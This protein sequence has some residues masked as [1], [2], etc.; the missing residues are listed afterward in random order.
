M[1]NTLSFFII[2]FFSI[3]FF[4]PMFRGP[5]EPVVQVGRPQRSHST[6]CAPLPYAG[7]KPN[8]QSSRGDFV[9]PSDTDP[10]N[11]CPKIWA[12]PFRQK[13]SRY[14]RKDRENIVGKTPARTQCRGNPGMKK[15]R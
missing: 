11:W 5:T 15:T 2:R 10:I 8:P 9:N 6:A 4:V 7:L 1:T 13:P 12:R 3:N 14:N